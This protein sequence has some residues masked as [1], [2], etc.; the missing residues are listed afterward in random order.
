MALV[1]SGHSAGVAWVHEVLVDVP[2]QASGLLW[3]AW[4]EF[5]SFGCAGGAGGDA[6]VHEVLV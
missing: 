6:W 1:G 3:V 5:I 2:D 4:M